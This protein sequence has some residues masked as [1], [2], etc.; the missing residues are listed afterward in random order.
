MKNNNH[1]EVQVGVHNPTT[2]YVEFLIEGISPL[3]T[4]QMHPED[5]LPGAKIDKDPNIMFERSIYYTAD[6]NYGFPATGIKSAIV[7][8]ARYTKRS[9]TSL[10]GLVWV[11]EQDEI[12]HLVYLNASQPTMQTD[13]VGGVR[14]QKTISISAQF[15]PWNIQFTVEFDKKMIQV[16]EV[17][18]LISIAGNYVGLGYRRVASG[19]NRRLGRFEIVDVK[20]S[21]EM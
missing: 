14:G 13:V 19:D 5:L 8:A 10:K 12:E 1:N 3:L 2:M 21:V 7:D 11:H 6:D 18:D 16:D 4:N 15:F 9:M 17:V 20:A